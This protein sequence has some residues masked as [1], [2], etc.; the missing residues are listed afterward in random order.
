MSKTLVERLE[1]MADDPYE[2]TDAPAKAARLF[3]E[4]AAALRA[5]ETSLHAADDLCKA[6]AAIVDEIREVVGLKGK[7]GSVVDAVK[8]LR[9]TGEGECEQL[10]Q[11]AFA[12][13][14]AS[15]NR[16]AAPTP[17]EPL[18]D[19][20]KESEVI[21][22]SEFAL[23]TP[24]G[25]TSTPLE[26]GM[27]VSK[28]GAGFKVTFAP[29]RDAGAVERALR[30][31]RCQHTVDEDGEPLLLV[32]ALTPKGDSTIARGEQEIELLAD[33]IAAAHPAPAQVDEAAVERAYQAF[34]ASRGTYEGEVP[35]DR[36][37]IRAALAAAQEKE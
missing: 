29:L 27:Y 4:A 16:P 22:A 32:D 18:R 36:E 11:D 8:A 14:H 35:I 3:R 33:H 21:E 17:A 5:T 34:I 23:A 37:D 9:A 28:P 25:E 1:A 10:V 6:N 15:T 12:G 20:L 2:A 30:S 19:A 26:I 24:D 13:R 31:Y 7:P